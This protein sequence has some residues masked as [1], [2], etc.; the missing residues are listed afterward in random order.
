MESLEHYLN[1]NPL[2]GFCSDSI[3]PYLQGCFYFIYFA[4]AFALAW[5]LFTLVKTLHTLSKKG[6]FL[7]KYS[8]INNV[9]YAHEMA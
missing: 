5:F 6:E 7:K 3:P 8:K 1:M 9:V 4:V 2:W